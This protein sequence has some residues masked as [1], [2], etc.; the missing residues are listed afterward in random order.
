MVLIPDPPHQTGAHCGSTS[1]RTLSEFYGWGLDEPTCFGLGSG[2]GFTYLELPESP[3]RAFFGRPVWLEAA[4][5]DH[6]GIGYEI[7]EGDEWTDVR[8]DLRE[9]ID[10]GRPMMVFTDIY[11]IDYYETDTH[12][13]PHTLLVVGYEDGEE[14]YVLAD[15]EFDALQRLPADRLRAAMNATHVV[16]LSNRR[17]IPTDPEPT[18]DLEAAMGR[19][20][21]ETASYHLAPA[22]SPRPLG[23]GIHGLEGIRRFAEELPDYHEYPDAD[24]TIRFAYQNVEKRG[25][26]G[27]AFR[28]LYAQFLETAAE[29]HPSV[30]ASVSERMHALADDWTDVGRQLRTASETD[31]SERLDLLEPASESV[32]DIADRERVLF[33]ELREAV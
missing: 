3:F 7:H 23:P 11:W 14:R 6:L 30:P 16:P 33:E 20:I 13:A 24:W 28:R 12:F 31:G 4:F 29:I 15:S 17:L 18:V 19:A 5:F 8:A 32:L 9:A 1:L 25:T 10:D 2:L 21:A 27:G 26:G 22:S